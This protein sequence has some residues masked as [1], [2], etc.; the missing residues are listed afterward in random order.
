MCNFDNDTGIDDVDG[1]IDDIVDFINIELP[2][3]LENANPEDIIE[4]LTCCECGAESICINENVLPIGTC[5]NCGYVNEV[6]ECNRCHLWFNSDED[7]RVTDDI[8]NFAKIV[9]TN[10]KMNNQIK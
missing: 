7:G 1:I 3:Y 2:S 10:W 4:Y 9:W 5:M 8:C 6:H